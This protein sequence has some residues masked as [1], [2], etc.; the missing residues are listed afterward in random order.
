MIIAV[1]GYIGT[2]KTTFSK[3][4]EE[5][6]FNNINVDSIGHSLLNLNPVKDKI[7]GSFGES[8]LGRDLKIDRKKLA[9]IVFNDDSK[10]QIL[11]SIMHSKMR[12][13][14]KHQIKTLDGKDVVIDAALFRKLGIDKLS[15][16]I[17]IIKSDLENIYQRLQHKYTKIQIINI[18]DSQEVPADSD[19]DI[20]INNNSSLKDLKIRAAE[21]ASKYLKKRS[22]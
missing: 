21:V 10:L 20:I 11:N 22:Q 3:Y 2:G 14:L 1:T 4:L 19:A 12:S 16:I 7:I 13:L 9:E 5:H 18:M 8:V 15:D 6:G 17:I